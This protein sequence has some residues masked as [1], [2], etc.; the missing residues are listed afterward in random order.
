MHIHIYIYVYV[1]R[2]CF[3]TQRSKGRYCRGLDRSMAFMKVFDRCKGRVLRNMFLSG[4][5]SRSTNGWRPRFGGS[6]H[7]C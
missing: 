6:E 3:I 1:C 4:A 2:V 5:A 7:W